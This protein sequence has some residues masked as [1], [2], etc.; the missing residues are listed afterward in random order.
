MKVKKTLPTQQDRN[1]QSF[2]DQCIEH[3][4]WDNNIVEQFRMSDC[5]Q[6]DCKIYY[7]SKKMDECIE[8][9]YRQYF[10]NNV[11]VYNE[12]YVKLDGFWSEFPCEYKSPKY[13]C[14]PLKGY[15]IRLTIL[16]RAALRK[17]TS[18]YDQVIIK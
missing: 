5:N 15:E 9:Q 13:T 18:I 8:I 1:I 16:I 3:N 6:Y 2:I 10:A 17:L 12:Y 14:D 4:K 7:F 11:N